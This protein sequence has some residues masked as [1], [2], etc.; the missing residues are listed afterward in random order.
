MMCL[1]WNLANVGSSQHW[2]NTDSVCAAAGANL[3]ASSN[4]HVDPAE[5]YLM[6]TNFL[7]D[8]ATYKS[9]GGDY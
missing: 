8:V 4:M 2:F 3:N 9:M 5:S 1:L 7:M 6:K